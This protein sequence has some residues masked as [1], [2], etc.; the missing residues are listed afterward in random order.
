MKQAAAAAA[1][2][3]SGSN[4]SSSLLEQHLGCSKPA[5]T[6]ILRVVDEAH[7]T[8]TTFVHVI[9]QG[10]LQGW[11]GSL[12][13]GASDTDRD[14]GESKA[15][16]EAAPHNSGPILRRRSWSASS[17][18]PTES[19]DTRLGVLQ[20]DTGADKLKSVRSVPGADSW[21]SKHTWRVVQSLPGASS[22]V[23]DAHTTLPCFAQ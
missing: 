1:A 18:K 14:V 6:G 2:R 7:S 21:I 15:G 4:S 11:E 13:T 19:T 12:P 17:Y 20:V 10:S 23:F 8:T 3:V 16:S 5:S 22:V 9:G